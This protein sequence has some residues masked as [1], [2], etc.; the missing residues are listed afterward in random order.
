MPVD[1][2]RVRHNPERL[3][4]P[5]YKFND[6]KGW[7]GNITRGAALGRSAIRKEDREYAGEI[8]IRRI[9]LDIG[10]Y[11]C[12]GTYFGGG[13]PLYWCANKEGTL[14]YMLR[15]KDRI[16]ARFQVLAEYPNAKVRR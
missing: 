14:D 13:Q 8:H 9:Y 16:D 4:L 7:C 3:P 12:N 6:P 5:S 1:S 15:A 11:D 10:G 2:S